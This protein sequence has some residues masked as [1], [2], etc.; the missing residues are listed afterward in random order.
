M[1]HYAIAAALAAAVV[2]AA[3]G[4]ALAEI[5]APTYGA[6]VEG[7]IANN[8]DGSP[9]MQGVQCGGAC[10]FVGTNSPT[11]TA[12]FSSASQSLGSPGTWGYSSASAD[13]ATGLLSVTA[14]S[15][16]NPPF[17]DNPLPFGSPA[18]ATAG[19]FT[20]IEFEGPGSSA[21]ISVTMSGTASDSGSAVLTSAINLNSCC[22]F[23]GGS[24]IDVS[25]GDW[26]ETEDFSVDY[27]VEYFLSAVLTV[28]TSGD[29]LPGT[30]TVTDPFTIGLPPGVTYTAGDPDFL[31]GSSAVPEPASLALLG[32]GL[33]GFGALRRR[34]RNAG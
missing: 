27:G 15:S 26:S 7:G 25:D 16:G 12:G 18:S 9:A 20:E 3:P 6:F 29:F 33:L 19:F 2:G 13:L 24:T 22:V 1:K 10:Y 34:R 11:G 21:I 4:G 32:G 8:G 17:Q 28:S 23:G 30:A 31:N 5:I 14:E